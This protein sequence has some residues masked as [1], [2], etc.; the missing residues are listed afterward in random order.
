MNDAG[1]SDIRVVLFDYGGVIAEEGF[2]EGLMEI[3]RNNGLAPDAF[4]EC[5]ADAVYETGYVT[6]H[7]D[8]SSYWAYL[9]NRTGIDGTDETLRREILDRFV[10]R[11]WVLDIVRHLRDSGLQT[12]ILSDQSNWLDELDGRDHFF[13]EFHRVFNSYHVGKGKRDPSLFEDV[14]R[15]LGVPCSRILFIDDNEGHVARADRLGIRVIRFQG[16]ESLI[17]GLKAL[18]LPV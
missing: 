12:A 2:R 3:G 10:L 13:K 18:G 1:A 9:R 11:P 17:G 7:A 14:S 15:E 16:K 8:E 6:G 5:A 4:F